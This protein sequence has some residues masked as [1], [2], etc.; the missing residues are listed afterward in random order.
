MFFFL[1]VPAEGRAKH[2]AS[3]GG[4][5]SVLEAPA[6]GELAL[7]VDVE[8]HSYLE[9][10]DR[11]NRDLVTVIELLSPSNKKLDVDREQYLAKRTQYLFSNVHLVEIDL[12]RGG[13]RLPVENLPKCDYYVLVSRAE[14]RP[15]MAL[16]PVQLRERLPRFPVPLRLPD[17]PAWLDLQPLLDRLYDAAG[18]AYHIYTGSPKPPLSADEEEWT[19]QFVPAAAL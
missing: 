7:T 13:P 4:P 14:D 3:D 2:S 1:V 12:L 16:W 18:Y 6:Y 19:K 10:R 11:R 5:T 15:A 9:L 17:S 8:R